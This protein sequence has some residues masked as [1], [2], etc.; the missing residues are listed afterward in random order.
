MR[1][2]HG[3]GSVEYLAILAMVM[4]VALTAVALM[5]FFP[6]LAGDAK[7]SQ[8]NIYWKGVARPIGIPEAVLMS[9]GG[10][11]PQSRLMFAMRNVEPESIVWG[12]G[13]VSIAG[14]DHLLLNEYKDAA[15]SVTL[16]PGG[17]FSRTSTATGYFIDDFACSVGTTYEI[18]FNLRYMKNGVTHVQKGAKPMV[19][20]CAPAAPGA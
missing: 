13:S 18:Y 7:R 19:L 2:L 20:N 4:V 16:G 17:E 11:G 14:E 1:T 6:G 8:G 10:A 12:G 15:I 9:R 5:G 3:Q